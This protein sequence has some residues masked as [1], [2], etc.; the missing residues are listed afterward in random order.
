MA[1]GPFATA[2][3]CFRCATAG[4]VTR[5]ERTSEGLETDLYRCPNGHVFGVDWRR[6]P[7]TAPTWP[8]SPAEVAA[9]ERLR[10]PL[11]PRPLAP[12]PPRHYVA[13][14][15]LPPAPALLAWLDA[16]RR[17]GDRLRLPIVLT[18]SDLGFSP[19]RARLGAAADAPAL[20]VDDSALGIAL[21]DRARHAAADAPTLALWLEGQWRGGDPPVFAV[22]R[23][24]AALGP[25]ELAAASAEAEVP[26]GTLP[27]SAA[28]AMDPA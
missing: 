5:A 20:L 3:P 21:A 22:L 26:A 18:R 2:L 23:V 7:P 8:P 27:P 6:G 15:P 14:H 4:L 13:A 25:G 10:P 16:R 24:G 1:G 17:A 9:I 19:R 28:P 11:S 12:E